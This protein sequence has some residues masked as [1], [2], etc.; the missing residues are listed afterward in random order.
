V[1]QLLSSVLAIAA[2]CSGGDGA[3]IDDSGLRN[4]YAK[5]TALFQRYYPNVTSRTSKATIHFEYDTRIFLIHE[6]LKTG[7]WQDAR[8]IRGPNRRGIL[9]DIELRKGPYLGAAVVP[10]T[11]DKR[12]FKLSVFAPYS[13]RLDSHLYV[14]LL[15]PADASVDFLREFSE[16][17]AAAMR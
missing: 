13:A 17:I 3:A 9:C 15:F 6:P 16:T 2:P 8:E 10:Q 4:L 14:H 11:F 1:V 5:L 12:Y 7:E